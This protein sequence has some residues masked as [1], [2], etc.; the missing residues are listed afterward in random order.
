MEINSGIDSIGYLTAPPVW[1]PKPTPTD[2]PVS[3]DVALEVRCHCVRARM[4][5]F[6]YVRTY[7]RACNHSRHA[8][9]DTGLVGSTA[10]VSNAAL[11]SFKRIRV[12]APH[13]DHNMHACARF[14]CGMRRVNRLRT[15]F[16]H[17]PATW[18][19]FFA[20]FELT[21]LLLTTTTTRTT[22]TTATTPTKTTT[23]TAAVALST[24]VVQLTAA[25]FREAFAW[26]AI[27]C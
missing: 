19:R 18:L 12:V 8:A 13:D 25:P 16:G 26:K 27:S 9:I 24:T 4:R 3:L 23:T 22:T 14:G 2:F 1:E 15:C 21:M 11:P 10:F 7:V 17:G 20:W 5:V 6:V